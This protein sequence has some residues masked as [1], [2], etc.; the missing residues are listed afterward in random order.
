MSQLS[1]PATLC[2]AKDWLL[3]NQW[4]RLLKNYLFSQGSPSWDCHP[5]QY[6]LFNT[7]YRS[8]TVP[9]LQWSYKITHIF[10]SKQEKACFKI[11]IVRSLTPTMT[12]NDTHTKFCQTINAAPTICKPLL[13]STPSC[14]TRFLEIVMEGRSRLWGGNWGVKSLPWEGA[15][16][17]RAWNGSSTSG[18][19]RVG[20]DSGGGVMGGISNSSS[21]RLGVWNVC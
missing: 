18:M 5:A 7:S 20:S 9:R 14:S 17:L 8:S 6:P 15:G 10:T 13:C 16:S 1:S 19:P 11:W 3:A 21:P 4:I 2:K 12:T